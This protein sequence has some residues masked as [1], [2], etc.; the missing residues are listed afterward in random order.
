[1][2]D[3]NLHALVIRNTNK[4]ERDFGKHAQTFFVNYAQVST[5]NENA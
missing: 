5:R 2:S 4:R 3:Y 1:M